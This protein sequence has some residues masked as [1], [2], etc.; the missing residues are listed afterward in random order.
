MRKVIF[1]ILI[2]IASKGV[3]Q[4][5]FMWSKKDSTNK[6]KEQ[7]FAVVKS[8]IVKDSNLYLQKEDK[9]KQVIVVKGFVKEIT[10]NNITFR[11]AYSVDFCYENKTFQVDILNLRFEPETE[12]LGENSDLNPKE[13]Y[14][15]TIICGISKDN[16]N[17]LMQKLKEDMQT[18][19]N[20]FYQK[21]KNE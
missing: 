21:L 20:Y 2:I 19:I 6:T 15:G 9:K 12:T 1:A 3:A 16:W 4:S 14:P 18:K 8:L 11:Y 5:P 13:I 17:Y 7:F 10:K